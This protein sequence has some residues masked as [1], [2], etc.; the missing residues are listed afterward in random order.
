MALLRNVPTRK[1]AKRVWSSVVYLSQELRDIIIS[2]NFIDVQKIGSDVLDYTLFLYDLNFYSMV[3][4]VKYSNSYIR[5][6]VRTICLELDKSFRQAGNN[7][8]ENFFFKQF[9]KV[10][11]AVREV[12]AST[13]GD[14]SAVAIFLCTL[15]F[16]CSESDINKNPDLISEIAEHF[17]KIIN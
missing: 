9:V 6:I 11:N 3:M 7:L 12:G 2:Y 10:S 17:K 4:C 16:G 8:E 14:L 13:S 1:K 15:E 5:T